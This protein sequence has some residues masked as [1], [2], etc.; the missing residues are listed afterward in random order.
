MLS[1]PDRPEEWQELLRQV[2]QGVYIERYETSRLRKDGQVI[3][4]SLTI[5][6]LLDESGRIIG[7]SK[8][9]RDITRL[10]KAEEERALLLAGEKEARKTAELLNLFGPRLLAELD[11]EKLGQEVTD[12]AALLTG[13]TFGAFFRRSPMRMAS[14]ISYTDCPAY[15]VKNLRP[16]RCLESPLF[17]RPHPRRDSALRRC[18]ARPSLRLPCEVIL[19]PPWWRGPERCWELFSS[20]TPCREDSPSLTKK[21]FVGIAAQAAIAMDNA[22]LFEQARWVQTELKRS[23]QELRRANQDLETFAYSA[24]HDL[25]EPL[26]T[27]AISA[28][29]LERSCGQTFRPGTPCFSKGFSRPRTA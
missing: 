14:P 12:I 16:S 11:A 10:K 17:L 27:I 22:R 15:R 20:A 1:P 28:Q 18:R 3:Q 4:V 6:P 23:N 24:S 21:S 19:R 9:A 25:Q 13:A 7:V 8:I 2:L 26:R 29:L 5:S